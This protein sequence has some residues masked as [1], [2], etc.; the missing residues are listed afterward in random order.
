MWQEI[1]FEQSTLKGL[2]FKHETVLLGL[3]ELLALFWV[4]DCFLASREVPKGYSA[5][6]ATSHQHV[7]RTTALREQLEILPSQYDIFVCGL[8]LK[9]VG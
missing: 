5:S 8:L 9:W 2:E 7:H 1:M 3:T 4:S 6:E